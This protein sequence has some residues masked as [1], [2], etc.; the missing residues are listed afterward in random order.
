MTEPTGQLSDVSRSRRTT[1]NCT[2]SAASVRSVIAIAGARA[3]ASGASGA[4]AAVASDRRRRLRERTRVAAAVAN[5]VAAQLKA[6]TAVECTIPVTVVRPR[7]TARR[8]AHSADAAGEA[9]TA[10]ASTDSAPRWGTG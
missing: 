7:G 10:R 9:V 3:D 6:S 8:R 5:A 2:R 4:A 1:T